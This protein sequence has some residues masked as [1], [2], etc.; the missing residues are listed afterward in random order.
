MSTHCLHLQIAS[1]FPQIPHHREFQRWVN[2]ALAESSDKKEI[3]LRIVDEAESATLNQ[4]YRHKSGPTNVLSFPYN[5][6]DNILAAIK[7]DLLG[8]IVICAPLVAQEAKIQSKTQQAH[9][10]HLV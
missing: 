6:P 8:D 1:N 7:N 3:N 10:A 5:I 4:Q 9:W 2:A